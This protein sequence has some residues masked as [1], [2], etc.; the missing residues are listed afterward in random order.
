MEDGWRKKR[1]ERRGGEGGNTEIEKCES[2]KGITD[3]HV[4]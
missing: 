1:E 3:E 2:H 4:H